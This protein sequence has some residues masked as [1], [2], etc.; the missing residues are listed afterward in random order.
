MHK[1]LGLTCGQKYLGYLILVK[2]NKNLFLLFFVNPIENSMPT[3]VQNILFLVSI[4]LYSYD[5]KYQFNDIHGIDF[6]KYFECLFFK[7]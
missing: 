7:Y 2:H 5:L 6:I 4:F 1:E 3:Y